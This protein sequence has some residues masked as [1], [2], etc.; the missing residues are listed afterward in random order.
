MFFPV[1]QR[2]DCFCFAC[3]GG[4]LLHDL[5]GGRSPRCHRVSSRGGQ[6]W[7]PNHTHRRHLLQVG[8]PAPWIKKKH[9]L[10]PPTLILNR[11]RCVKSLVVLA[12]FSVFC[13]TRPQAFFFAVL[14]GFQV[15]LTPV[16]L[17]ALFPFSSQACRTPRC[18]P[19]SPKPPTRSA[20]KN[21]NL[22]TPSPLPNI[23]RTFWFTRPTLERQSL[24]S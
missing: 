20:G 23:L 7:P 17:F 10:P 15:V 14:F 11:S 18:T 5:L 12:T 19:T 6:P 1:K 22:N 8:L 16:T 2:H 21:C 3:E 9:H 13:Q 4:R 24:V